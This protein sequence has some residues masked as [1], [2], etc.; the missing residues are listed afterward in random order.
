MNGIQVYVTDWGQHIVQGIE[1]D[2]NGSPG[3][4]QQL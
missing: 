4:K 2:T 1:K 3:G